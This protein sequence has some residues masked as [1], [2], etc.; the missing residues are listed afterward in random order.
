MQAL[1]PRVVD[2]VWAAIEGLL[3]PLPADT[4]PLGC[5]RRRISDRD[6]FSGILLRLVTGCS[7]DVAAR[8]TTAGETT[9]RA[10]RTLWLQAGVFD[11][12]VEEALAGYDRIIGL[13]LG[14]AADGLAIASWTA[15][16]TVGTTR[17]S[18]TSGNRRVADG[19]LAR[20]ASARAAARNTPSSRDVLRLPST[21]LNKPGKTSALFT[22]LG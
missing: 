13:D 20:P 19:R 2:A 21:P 6:C 1:N 3:P 14:C 17:G 7:W 18:K 10:R 8:F 15:A 16:A 4:H 9:L 5:H 12:L 22:W 11:R